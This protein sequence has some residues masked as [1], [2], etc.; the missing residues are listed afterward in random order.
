MKAKVNIL[1]MLVLFGAVFSA[2]CA[3]LQ[4]GTEDQKKNAEVKMVAIQEKIGGGLQSGALTPDQSQQFLTT[5][6]SIRTDHTGLSDQRATVEEWNRLN[7]RLDVL[8][9]EINRALAPVARFE[10]PRIETRIVALQRAIDEGKRAGRFPLS[11][12]QEFQDR[13]NLIRNDYFRMM[14]EGKFGNQAEKENIY[15]RLD[16]LESNFNKYP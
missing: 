10:D 8:G 5:L 9:D 15:K 12:G 16:L 14:Q 13:L 1:A 2:G 7:G 6:K 11:D 4:T 3:Y